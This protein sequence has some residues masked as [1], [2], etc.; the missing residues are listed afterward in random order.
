M[1]KYFVPVEQFKKINSPEVAYILGM[2]WADGYITKRRKNSWVIR[3]ELVKEDMDNILP[4]FQAVGT[5]GIYTRQPKGNRQ[6]T[7]ALV[8]TDTELGS[9]L[10]ENDYLEK[11]FCSADKILSKIP[12]HLKHYWF[13]GYFDGDGGIS[14][15]G[16]KYPVVTFSG[17]YKQEFSFL[18]NLLDSIQCTYHYRQ[19]SFT[20]N[21]KTQTSSKVVLNNRQ[22]AKYFSDYIY[23]NDWFGLERKKIRFEQALSAV[24]CIGNRYYTYGN[25]TKTLTEWSKSLQIN[26]DTLKARLRN[27]WSV[28]RTF[29][30]AVRIFKAYDRKNYN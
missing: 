8:I 5:W 18:F 4:I 15:G 9:F 21:N 11:S 1:K 3:L 25:D 23:Q 2:L 16:G 19:I 13:R 27:N 24:N 28:E 14:L 10:V 26:R 17:S 7:T 22:S 20:K 12:N 30:T 6:S 29:T